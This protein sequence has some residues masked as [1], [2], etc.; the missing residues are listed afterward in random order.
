MVASVLYNQ[1][2][3]ERRFTD[4]ST[5]M[6]YINVL[7]Y[8]SLTKTYNSTTH[9]TGLNTDY[10]MTCCC[11]NVIDIVLIDSSNKIQNIDNHTKHIQ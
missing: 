10:G 4:C 9:R 7:H 8:R 11:N 2:I 6:T 5:C 1:V 3:F